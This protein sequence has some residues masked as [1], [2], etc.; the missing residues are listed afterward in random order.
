M[1]QRYFLFSNKNETEWKQEK[2]VS[3]IQLVVYFS[4]FSIEIHIK[5]GAI[6]SLLSTRGHNRAPNLF[7]HFWMN[8]LYFFQIQTS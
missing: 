2:T 3:E 5:L 8:G 7:S 4:D 1:S 6:D